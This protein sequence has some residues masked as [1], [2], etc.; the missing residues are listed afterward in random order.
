MLPAV[1]VPIAA[2]HRQK[3]RLSLWIFLLAGGLPALVLGG[4]GAL[5]LFTG[6]L[7]FVPSLAITT[8]GILVPL[9][10]IVMLLVT[11][12]VRLAV[13]EDVL[14]VQ[15]GAHHLRV[16][17]DEI[18]SVEIAPAPRRSTS[19]GVAARATMN[20]DVVYSM[21]GSKRCAL[22]LHRRGDRGATILVCRQPDA[23]VEAIEAARAR[24][25]GVAREVDEHA[26]TAEGPAQPSSSEASTVP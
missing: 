21:L 23:V 25:E 10:S 19:M 7:P 12:V 2:L 15:V 26:I 24:G 9:L 8:M 18:T 4:G 17:I 20:G 22:H 5:L 13:F 1:S 11:G 16:P 6:L 3:A 14:E